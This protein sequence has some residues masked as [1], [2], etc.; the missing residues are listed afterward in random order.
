VDDLPGPVMVCVV[1]A[2]GGCALLL[3]FVVWVFFSAIL[4]G[5]I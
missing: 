1:A 3:L 4:E 2:G 5:G